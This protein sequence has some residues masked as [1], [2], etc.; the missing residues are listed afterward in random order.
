[1]RFRLLLLLLPALLAGACMYPSG[2]WLP[3][4]V[5]P[6]YRDVAF[7]AIAVL[8]DTSAYDWRKECEDAVAAEL[9]DNDVQAGPASWFLVPMREWTLAQR[10]SVLTGRGY[11]ACLAIRVVQSSSEEVYVPQNR[12][13]KTDRVPIKEQVR[14]RVDGKTV[15][16]D[17]IVGW[18]DVSTT[19]T[20]GGYYSTRRTCTFRID[21]IDLASD[22][23][24]WSA[25][26]SSVMDTFSMDDF[27]SRISRQ[28]LA[29]RIARQRRSSQG[30]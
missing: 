4:F 22:R 21:L 18:R 2:P 27:A 29:D 30:K 6:A 3:S 10:D 13:T 15:V 25:E 12:V 14:V 5:D 11:D 28:L 26:Y 1:V 16:K 7:R 17:S 9:M 8:A 20:E 23:S 19:R 24:A